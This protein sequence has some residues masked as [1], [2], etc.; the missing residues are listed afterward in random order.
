MAEKEVSK[1]EVEQELNKKAD[2]VSQEQLAEALEN[3]SKVELI[4]KHVGKLAKYWD[5]VKW[6]YSLIR[7]YF[8]GNYKQ[9][10]WRT[11]AL[12]VA[13]LA[14]VLAPFDLIPDFILGIGW[15]DDCMCLA[16]ALAV[17]KMDLDEYKAWKKTQDS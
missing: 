11:I 8:S 17:A 7:D 10:P 12:L 1:E 14:Y 16:G 2:G 13:S 3:Q 15:A 9:V 4:F 6:V 5:E